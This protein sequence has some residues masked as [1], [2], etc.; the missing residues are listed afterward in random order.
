MKLTVTEDLF[1]VSEWILNLSTYT[2]A[3]F[4]GFR[5]AGLQLLSRARQ[6][7]KEPRDVFSL[8]VLIP[9]LNAKITGIIKYSMPFTKQRVAGGCDV[10]V[11]CG[12][13]VDAVDQPESVIN[14][15]VHL[16]TKV[17]LIT[18]L[19]LIHFRISLAFFGFCGGGCRN[20]RGLDNAALAEHEPIFLR[21]LVT[22]L[23]TTLTRA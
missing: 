7:N 22:S 14:V 23:N 13:G 17:P 10:T 18:Y 5:L 20:N 1:K 21:C 4:P 11:I 8:F 16:H 2:R 6:F 19:D 9:L 3:G 12:R 15:D